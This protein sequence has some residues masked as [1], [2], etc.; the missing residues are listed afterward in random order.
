[1]DATTAHLYDYM[2]PT[3]NQQIA[4]RQQHSMGESVPSIHDIRSIN[5]TASN[6]VKMENAAATQR[7]HASIFA[8][9]SNGLTGDNQRKLANYW[10]QTITDTETREHDFKT[11][12]LP[13]A[14]IKKVMKADEDVKMISAEAP[15]LFAKAAE[16]FI[17]ELTMRAWIHAE[18]NKRRTLQRSDIANAISRSDMFDFLIDIVPREE[19]INSVSG[20]G[21]ADSAPVA[22]AAGGFIGMNHHGIQ[23]HAQ[24]QANL[25]SRPDAQEA[26]YYGQQMMD[27]DQSNGAYQHTQPVQHQVHGSHMGYDQHRY[28]M[29]PAT[30][31]NM[32]NNHPAYLDHMSYPQGYQQHNGNPHPYTSPYANPYA[33]TGPILPSLQQRAK[34]SNGD[35][36]DRG[37]GHR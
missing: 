17:T 27:K 33:P 28:G 6:E 3:T 34:D 37:Y 10:Q 24:Q 22:G 21:D 18:E 14:R 7:Q 4:Q 19:F 2:R 31:S 1:M 35:G 23:V 32:G 26:Q 15:I 11:H 30:L 13:L 20:S 8:N 12:A 9:A 29:P 25:Q 16:I 36:S 5:G